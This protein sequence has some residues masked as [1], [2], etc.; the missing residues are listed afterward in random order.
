[1]PNDDRAPQMFEN[2]NGLSSVTTVSSH[3]DPLRS[4]IGVDVVR[5]DIA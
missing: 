1:M 2:T 4:R 5:T 3:S